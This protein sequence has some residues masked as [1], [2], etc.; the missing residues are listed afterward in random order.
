MVDL[1]RYGLMSVG[2]AISTMA[3]KGLAAWLTNSVGL[4]SDAA[5]SLV[6]LVAAMVAVVTLKVAIR[7][8]D[9]SHPFGHSKAEYFSAI[10][11]GVM[12]FVAAAVIIYTAIMRIIR[13]VMPEQLGIGLLISVGASLINGGV[14]VVLLRA[15]GRHRSATLT[16]D[17]RHLMTDVITSAAVLIGV[18]L[19]ALTHRQVLDPIVALLAGF[20]ILYTGWRL[21]RHSVDGLM[22]V[23][24]PAELT[25]QLTTVLDEHRADGIA[26]HAIRTRESG[27][28]RFME[29]HVLVPDDWT[30]KQGH[31]FAEDVADALRTVEPD[32]RVMAHLEPVD[33]DRSYEDMDV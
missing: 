10:V 17:G 30:V 24:L 26:F 28:R 25:T 6:N 32:L 3:I 5:E 9:D 11:E 29:F 16:A 15:G 14:A 8:P 18:G 31:D 4:W 13:P 20:N 7:P 33:D 12:I 21:I 1:T 22:D 19:V 27:H 23:A 2:A